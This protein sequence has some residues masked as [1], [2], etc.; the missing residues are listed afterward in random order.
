[1]ADLDPGRQKITEKIGKNTR[2][3]MLGTGV[4]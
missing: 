1:M 2:I 3:I 4:C